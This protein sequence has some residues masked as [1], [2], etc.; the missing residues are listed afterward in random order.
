MWVAVPLPLRKNLN[1]LQCPAP[2]CSKS[3][4]GYG[5]HCSRHRNQLRANGA[6]TQAAIRTGELK[7]YLDRVQEYRDPHP[8]TPFW[9]TLED[10]F[11][12]F[13]VDCGSAT[14]AL[15]GSASNR[16][17]WTREARE[18]VQNLYQRVDPWLVCKTSLAVAL[19]RHFNPRRF[20]SDAAYTRQHVRCLRRLAPSNY[21][22]TRCRRT[23]NIS[24]HLDILHTQTA[25]LLGHWMNDLFGLAGEILSR[26]IERKENRQLAQKEAFRAALTSLPE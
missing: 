18:V 22:R 25:V 19:Y 17:R 8:E 20:V 6:A 14:P 23:G 1:A 4:H 15:S 9:S 2:G 24:T 11:K 21:R 26:W 3:S 13:A 5:H 12:T 16:H 10:A 7:T